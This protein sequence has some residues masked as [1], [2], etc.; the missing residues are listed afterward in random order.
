VKLT[1]RK[2]SI[3]EIAEGNL[4]YAACSVSFGTQILCEDFAGG[5][6][7][8]TTVETAFRLKPKSGKGMPFLPTHKGMG[9]HGN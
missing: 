7:F 4:G 9:F 2:W 6:S 3:G 8:D 1:A 5:A